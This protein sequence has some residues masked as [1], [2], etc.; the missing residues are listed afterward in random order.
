MKAGNITNYIFISAVLILINSQA[1]LCSGRETHEIR[2]DMIAGGAVH[3]SDKHIDAN[4]LHDSPLGYNFVLDANKAKEQ[5]QNSINFTINDF[6]VSPTQTSTIELT[7]MRPVIDGNTKFLTTTFDG[8]IELPAPVVHSF[9][10]KIMGQPKSVV[11]LNYVNGFLI[12]SITGEDGRE[13]IL[14][15]VQNNLSQG[16]HIITGI[17]NFQFPGL[18]I[19]DSPLDFDGTEL[20]KQQLKEKLNKKL[21][22]NTT[23]SEELL[24]IEVAVETDSEFYKATGSDLELAQAYTIAIYTLVSRIYE[25]FL[26]ITIYIPWLKIWT[27]EPADPYNAKGN[28]ITLRDKAKP[29]WAD[30]Y[31]DVERDVYQVATA[32]SYGGGG[33]GYFGALCGK[34]YNGMSVISVQGRNNLPTFNYAYD[35]YLT[36]HE[37][38]HN[39]NGRHTHSCF[40]DNAPLDT[41]WIDTGCLPEETELQ[42]NPGSVMSYCGVA[43]SQNGLGYYSRQIFLPQNVALIRSTA[44]NAPCATPPADATVLLVYPHGSESFPP[45]QPVEIRWTSEKVL[46][47]DLE[48]SDD[49][50]QTWSIIAR[51]LPASSRSY[52]WIAA[53]ICSN[54]LM[55]RISNSIDS[56]V[57]DQTILPFSIHKEDPDGLVA[58]YP[59]NGNSDDEQFCGYYDADGINNPALASDRFGR[60]GKA[61]QFDGNS[62]LLAEKFDSQFDELSFSYW[63]NS[64]DNSGKKFIFGTDYQSGSSFSTYYWAGQAG[65]SYYIQGQSGPMQ[66]WGGV[67]P[68]NSWHHVAFTYGG[69]T[70]KIYVNG[71]LKSEESGVEIRRL[72]QRAGVP[73][74]I[75]SRKNKENFF[76]KIDDIRIYKR[77]LS[78]DDILALYNE[79]IPAAPELLQPP[80]GA[81]NQPDSPTLRWQGNASKYHLQAGT[82][83]GFDSG[84]LVYDGSELSGTS[85]ILDNLQPETNYYWRVAG[86]NS[87]GH[88]GWSETFSFRTDVVQSIDGSADVSNSEII[89]N[90]PNPFGEFT[91][92]R[93]RINKPCRVSATLINHLGVVVRQLSSGY[94]Q[95]GFYDRLINSDGLAEGF[96]LFRLEAC[97]EI[98]TR[99]ILHVK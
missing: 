9:S 51:N 86:I 46:N 76:G 52:N 79:A 96:Y 2:F 73:F 69:T 13:Y 19:N 36:A 47:I 30:N 89:T 6:P 22:S 33:W 39:L 66:I 8:D 48:F 85:Y 42:P 44:E 27:D 26:N 80:N 21:N 55:I 49:E 25:D 23:M 99:K 5:L 67:V 60:E 68:I 77:V 38:G 14:G 84:S 32:I 70:A 63:F 24:E 4:D 53:D 29:Y 57:N 82:E 31:A 35:I 65:V 7:R 87:N 18:N 98:H 41:C 10:G 81:E 95:A 15:P 93:F 91:K 62:Y 12:G 28:Y 58:F 17:E 61:Y 92:V 97:G 40:W 37:L 75:G 11:V 56:D 20:L 71:E 72:K 43:N 54:K 94:L 90:Y 50:G 1:S 83:A 74:Y 3:Q 64:A 88:G 78:D 34:K 16:E 45:G 59:F